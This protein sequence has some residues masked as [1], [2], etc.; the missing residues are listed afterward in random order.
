MGLTVKRVERV[1]EP[2]RY[3]DGNHAGQANHGPQTIYSASANYSSKTVLKYRRTGM[4]LRNRFLQMAAPASSTGSRTN[5]PRRYLSYTKTTIHP[6]G[7]WL[8]DPP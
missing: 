3:G 7:R 5:C 8:R 2:G 4:V 1:K 6:G